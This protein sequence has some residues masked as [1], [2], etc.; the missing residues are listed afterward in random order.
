MLSVGNGANFGVRAPKYSTQG[1]A[2]MHLCLPEARHYFSKRGVCPLAPTN[3]VILLFSLL[4]GNKNTI[5]LHG[6]VPK[7]ILRLLT[8]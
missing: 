3:D 8:Q 5:L 2:V 1:L 6:I 4:L 7:T